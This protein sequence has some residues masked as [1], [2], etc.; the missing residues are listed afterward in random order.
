MHRLFAFAIA[1]LCSCCASAAQEH[2][3]VRVLF[4]G[5]SITYVGN[6]P[7]VLDALAASQMR[8]VQSDMIVR[9]GATLTD[10]IADRSVERAVSLRHYDYVVLQERGGDLL[11]SFG[12]KSCKDAVAALGGLARIARARGAKPVCL[13]TYQTNPMVSR[14]LVAAESEAAARWSVA[15][16]P[17]SDRLQAGMQAHPSAGWLYAD[18]AHP[19]HDLALLEAVLL[20]RELFGTAPVPVDL[21]VDAPM[22]TPHAKFTPPSPTSKGNSQDGIASSQSYSKSTIAAVLDV[23]ATK[24]P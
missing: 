5:N 13:G 19:G 18:G 6:L 3:P 10:R 1:L 9:G 16:V 15:Y 7:A 21:R 14:H 2:A 12:P 17:T 11:C 22:Y 24:A 23:A 8:P 4:V 20:Y